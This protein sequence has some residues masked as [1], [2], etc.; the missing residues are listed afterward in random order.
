METTYLS[1]RS[2]AAAN[3]RMLES[4]RWLR[5]RPETADVTHG[6]DVRVYSDS[7]KAEHFVEGKLTGGRGICYWLET[8]LEGER[9]TVE[10]DVFLQNTHG[11]TILREVS[12]TVPLEP[13]LMSTLST[14]A[15]N[16]WEMR[17]RDLE[18]AIGAG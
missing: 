4:Y 1:L 18:N 14:M 13:M 17:E 12:S 9:C 2:I 3:E 10:A 11:Q 8:R 6:S 15:D 7:V 16:L 5:D